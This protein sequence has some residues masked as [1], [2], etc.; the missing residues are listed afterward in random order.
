MIMIEDVSSGVDMETII[1]IKNITDSI[2]IEI[3]KKII[4][5]KNDKTQE[6]NKA[7]TSIS[8][9]I[10]KSRLLISTKE[11]NKMTPPTSSL[12]VH[13]VSI[14]P[15]SSNNIRAPSHSCSTTMVP[16]FPSLINMASFSSSINL[17]IHSSSKI[18]YFGNLSYDCDEFDPYIIPYSSNFIV[19]ESLPHSRVLVYFDSSTK[20][21]KERILEVEKNDKCLPN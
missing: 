17:E 20:I 14:I 19:S 8:I 7:S 1:K 9:E 2:T 4:D 6:C 18:N 13:M 3:V 15:S 10:I 5:T 16:P 11:V 12:E 21:L